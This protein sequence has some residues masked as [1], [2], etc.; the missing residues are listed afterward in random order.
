MLPCFSNKTLEN[1]TKII[2]V[3]PKEFTTW[4]AAQDTVA[5]NWMRAMQFTGAVGGTCL[6][7]SQTGQLQ[8]VI[9]GV[10]DDYRF[11][12]VGSL[13]ASLPAGDYY[14][15]LAA[16]RYNQAAI[17]WGLGAYQF[18]KYKQP[19][20]ESAKLVLID[21][22]DSAYIHN[23]L[24]SI[25][26]TRDLI[27]TP[28]NDLGPSHLSDYAKQLSDTYQARFNQI[29][30]DELLKNNFPAIHAVGRASDNAPRLIDIRWGNPAHRKVTL[31]GKGV[32]FDT[33]GLDLKSSSGMILMKK[34]M[35]G[36]ANVLGLARMIMCAQLPICLRVLI[37]AV[38]NVI[39]GNAYR[40]SDVIKSRK[41]IT[42]E[43]GN[44]D[45]EG[46][47]VL[48]DALTEAVSEK[49]DL[50][51]DMATLT[52]AARVALGTE[53]PAVFA[54]HDETIDALLMHSKEQ[55]DPVWRMPLF[56]AYRDS[57][58]SAIADINNDSSD[59]YG[60]AI[61]A[62]LFLK[63]FVPDT[64][65]WLHFDLMAWNIKTRPGRPQGGE[66]M[67]IRALFA[68]LSKAPS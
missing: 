47:V 50:L 40:P 43:I 61:T 35:G 68:F 14:F 27:N 29:V 36:A 62:G 44:T 6:M 58:N 53:L 56:S 34:D 4:L 65:P 3:P 21:K 7:P 22:T 66:A 30:G 41:G 52:G 9:M 8:Q 2:L 33:G 39:S 54:N 51:I 5:Q 38:E 13:S 46:R 42:I 63:E 45:A 17:A 23:M 24:E 48:S 18:S 55:Q 1:A 10:S 60:G 64:I 26:L 28:P 49:P 59:S 16:E 67:A 37:P 15:D 25:Y 32:C 12:E 11:W 31:V 19:A 20:R 57:I